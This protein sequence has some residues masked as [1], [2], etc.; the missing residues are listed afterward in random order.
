VAIPHDP[1]RLA[2]RLI[3]GL[4]FL[5]AFLVLLPAMAEAQDLVY[6]SAVTG[7]TLRMA[8]LDSGAAPSTVFPFAAG[9]FP[10]GIAIDAAVGKVYWAE[11]GT[12]RIRAGNLDGSGSPATVVTETPGAAPSGLALDPAANRLYW[13]DEGSGAI[14]AANLDGSDPQTLFTEPG[15]DLSG[16]AV[17]PAGGR[18]YWADRGGSLIRTGSLDG[19]GV[20]TT[21]FSDPGDLRSVAVDRAS[22][23]IYWVNQGGEG[24]VRVAN[25]DGSGAPGSLSIEGAS[26]GT[27]GLALDVDAGS[28]Y[29]THAR[30]SD[31][32]QVVRR[33]LLTPSISTSVDD[34]PVS[35]RPLFMALLRRP[36]AASPPAIAGTPGAGS[37]LTC[38]T[39]AWRPD[40]PSWSL[41]RAPQSFAFQWTRDGAD[42]PGAT[43]ASFTPGDAGSYACR[44]TAAN[45]A[46]PADATSAAVSVSVPAPPAPPSPPPSPPAKPG[47]ASARI[48]L[49][50][51][52]PKGS[53]APLRLTCT[54]SGLARCAGTV[55]L[56]ARPSCGRTKG[57][58]PVTT[59]GRASF[60]SASGTATVSIRLS[61]CARKHLARRGDLKGMA[62]VRTKQA[63]GSGTRETSRRT[64]RILAPK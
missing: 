38:S 18:L 23:R 63:P 6:W 19:T 42:V 54:V 29:L 61:S 15:A 3:A 58:P 35:S 40:M 2:L 13:T 62:I 47:S 5:V 48:A 27:A 45:A 36:A 14:R 33:S 64:V 16:I 51:L 22:G 26:A 20:A 12:D 21:L 41:S 9:T 37:P 4:A 57:T 28:F 55:A 32:G 44:V 25:L 1:R 30:D 60:S 53:A 11:S 59:V 34:P 7:D 10:A 31:V 39:G 52:T 24:P 56:S 46:G 17:D 8:D 43:S 49:T 50:R